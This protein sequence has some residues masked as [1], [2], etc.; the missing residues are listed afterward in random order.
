MA[1]MKGQQQSVFDYDFTEVEA[2]THKQYL[3]RNEMLS[4]VMEFKGVQYNDEEKALQR[5]YSYYEPNREFTGKR[6]DVKLK[7]IDD[8]TFVDNGYR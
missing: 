3:D 6:E 8:G 1:I 5:K 2:K 4:E 7:K